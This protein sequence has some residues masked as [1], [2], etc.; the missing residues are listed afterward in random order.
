MFYG[1]NEDTGRCIWSIDHPPSIP[2]GVVVLASDEQLSISEIMLVTDDEGNHSI[3]DIVY[4]ASE[5]LELAKHEQ[6]IKMQEAK[7]K[8]DILI[9]VVEFTPSD[10]VSVELKA[11]RK[12]RAELYAM[13]FS[14]INS[15]KWPTIPVSKD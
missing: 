11:W 13:D 15:V 14:T 9:D 6:V 8:I 12:Y 7:N 4:T 2:E 5:L 10:A 1:F 3:G